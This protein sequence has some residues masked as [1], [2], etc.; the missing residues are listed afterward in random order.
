MLRMVQEHYLNRML[1][2]LALMPPGM[3]AEILTA[4]EKMSGVV[5]GFARN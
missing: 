1:G 3:T 5:M 4:S 2:L